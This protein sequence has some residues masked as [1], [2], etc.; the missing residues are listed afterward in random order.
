MKD[1]IM[2]KHASEAQIVKILE[3]FRGGA[4]ADDLC[5]TYGLAR[6]TLYKWRDKYGY[7]PISEV[8]RIKYLEHENQKLKAM[9]AEL[10][11]RN[12]ALKDIIAKKL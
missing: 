5:R 11:L 3:E 8:K 10:S 9:Y 4:K 7:M 6:S 1:K 2:T 12:E